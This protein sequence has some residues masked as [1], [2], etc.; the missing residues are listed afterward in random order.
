MEIL[1]AKAHAKLNLSLDV[2]SGRADGYHDLCM[3]MQSV[4]LHDDLAISLNRTGE[5][6]AQT[7]IGRASCR[8]RV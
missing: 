2:L 8:E 5:F 6:A 4:A 3:I 7:K 1:R